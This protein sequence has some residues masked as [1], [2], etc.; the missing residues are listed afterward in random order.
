[1]CGGRRKCRK[2]ESMQPKK[3]HRHFPFGG[4]LLAFVF[5]LGNVR[6]PTSGVPRFSEKSRPCGRP[7]CWFSSSG[8]ASLA[9]PS[10]RSCF[11]VIILNVECGCG[12]RKNQQFCILLSTIARL[13]VVSKQLCGHICEVSKLIL[14]S[15]RLTERCPRSTCYFSI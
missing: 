10:P 11:F 1:M 4:S 5:I 15:P 2:T 13:Q 12:A 3:V 8:D 14:R 6:K 9:C 7:A